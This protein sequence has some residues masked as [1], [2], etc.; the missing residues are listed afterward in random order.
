MIKKTIF[1]V[2]IFL[3]SSLAGCI[4]EEQTIVKEEIIFFQ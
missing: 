4:A 3:V 1:L 2:F